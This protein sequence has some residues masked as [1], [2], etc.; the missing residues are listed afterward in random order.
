ME[1]KKIVEK[2]ES[3]KVGFNFIS[4]LVALLA[5]NQFY[6]I[7]TELLYPFAKEIDNKY[8]RQRYFLLFLHLPDKIAIGIHIDVLTLDSTVLAEFNDIRYVI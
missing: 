7:A 2:I 1:A 6:E 8:A 3:K 4:Q 5:K